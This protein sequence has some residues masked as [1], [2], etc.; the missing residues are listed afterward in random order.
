MPLTAA[1]DLR[2]VV[3]S[4]LGGLGATDGAPVNYTWVPV[5]A[6]LLL[7]PWAVLLGLLVLRPNR[8]ASAWLIWLP[9]GIM[10]GL[11][12]APIE[13]LPGGVD[14]LLDDVAAYAVGLA[15]VWL[16]A[17]YLR[18]RHR[19]VTFLCVLAT[20]IGFGILALAS[21][22][23]LSSL[24]PE[25]IPAS[26]LLGMG[27][28]A[29]S[30]ALILSGKIC[31][32]QWR[33]FALCLWVLVL[34]AVSWMVMVAPFFAFDAIVQGVMLPWFYVL[35]FLCTAAIITFG[36]MLPFL[37][38]SL[39]SPFYRERLKLLMHIEPAAPPVLP[40]NGAKDRSAAN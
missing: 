7:V 10:F 31:R 40:E 13:N 28:L 27:T 26:I 21:K 35:G 36:T 12:S 33:P 39:A 18:Q 15:G 23:S 34:L 9:L 5:D 29:S 19:F 24:S 30:V 2:I 38:L 14:F 32:G 3:S 22:Q 11:A 6:P 17:G 37:V 20:F 4:D 8:R 25:V 1:G 16:L